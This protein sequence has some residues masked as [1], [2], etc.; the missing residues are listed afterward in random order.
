MQWKLLGIHEEDARE[1]SYMGDPEPELSIFCYQTRLP[2]QGQG[3]QPSH[4]AFDL[5]FALPA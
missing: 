4:K 3:H 2:V 5:Q 1:N